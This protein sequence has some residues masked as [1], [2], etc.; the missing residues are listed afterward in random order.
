MLPKNLIEKLIYEFYLSKL[1]LKHQ[2]DILV[3]C[4]NELIHELC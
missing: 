3:E 2:E 4:L 1:A